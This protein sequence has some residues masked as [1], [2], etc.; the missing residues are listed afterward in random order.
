MNFMATSRINFLK[1]TIPL[2]MY[3]L[4]SLK[5]IILNVFVITEPR[6]IDK[7]PFP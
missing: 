2:S 1:I 3:T 7:T 6:E 5:Y 4:T